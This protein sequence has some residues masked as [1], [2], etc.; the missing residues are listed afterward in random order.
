M[1]SRIKN[2][3]PAVLKKLK[4]LQGDVLFENFG[5]SDSDIEELSKE[6]SVLFHFAATLK[7][8]APLKDNVDMNTSGTMRTLNV[9]RRL[10]NLLAF[11]HLST[12]FCYPDYEVLDEKV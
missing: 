2:E 10:K 9:A 5:L 8:E 6:I 3:R 4:P 7:L 12:A 11:I 1:F